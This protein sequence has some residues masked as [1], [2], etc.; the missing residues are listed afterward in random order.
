[1]RLSDY[2]FKAGVVASTALRIRWFHTLRALAVS[3]VLGYCFVDIILREIS[4]ELYPVRASFAFGR[5]LR[6]AVG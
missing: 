4:I 3:V 1:M 2:V 5:V 6:G